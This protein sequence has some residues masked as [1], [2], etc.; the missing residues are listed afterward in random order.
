MEKQTELIN[1][2]N[3]AIQDTHQNPELN[4]FLT[5]F[6]NDLK[7]TGF[8]STQSAKFPHQI[9]KIIA[10]SSSSKLPSSVSDVMSALQKKNI[11]WNAAR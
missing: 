6:L 8:D 5:S 4:S 9:S 10:Q 1:L 11:W 7:T 2:L 3:K